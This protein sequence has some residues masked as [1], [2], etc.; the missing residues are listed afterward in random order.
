M[1]NELAPPLERGGAPTGVQSLLEERYILSD[2]TVRKRKGAYP[3]LSQET[4]F[5]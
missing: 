5:L 3:L 1:V 2:V 4:M